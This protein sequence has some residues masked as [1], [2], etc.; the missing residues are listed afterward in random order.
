MA[1]TRLQDVLFYSLES[2]SKAYRRFAQARLHAKGIDITIDQW[3]VLKTIHE[4][5]DMMLQ[6][7]GTTVFKDFAS[8][9]R[10]VQLLER[11]RFLRRKPHPSDGRRSVL[12]L[13]RSG[14]AV[15]RTVEPIAKANRKKALAGIDAKQV[16]RLRTVLKRI[17]KNC[18]PR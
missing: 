6:D 8:V 15:I 10:I 17:N 2:A 11:K 12:A 18:E 13:T 1:D 9:T 16:A 5:P 4:N 3:L 14:E 7:V